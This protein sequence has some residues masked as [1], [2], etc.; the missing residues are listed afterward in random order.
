MGAVKLLVKPVLCNPV[1]LRRRMRGLFRTVVGE[2]G[3]APFCKLAAGFIMKRPVGRS[4]AVGKIAREKGISARPMVVHRY[5]RPESA[6]HF[7]KGAGFG[8]C[9]IAVVESDLGADAA[10]SI[11]ARYRVRT[12]RPGQAFVSTAGSGATV[13]LV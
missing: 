3:I 4:A 9:A 13:E 12:G 1:N 6:R 8:G 2:S 10:E 5:L 7:D 11:M